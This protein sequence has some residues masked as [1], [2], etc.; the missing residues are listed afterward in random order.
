MP[1][2]RAPSPR[3]TPKPIVRRKRGQSGFTLVE[4][5]IA[6]GILALSLSVVFGALSNGIWQVR[7][8]DAGAQA[9][10]LVQSVLARVGT[11]VPLREGQA[12]GQFPGGF[13]WHL[14]VQGFGDAADRQV[15]PV[16]AYAVTAE[17]FWEDASQRRSVLVRTLR[18]G[19][20]EPAR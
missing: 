7:Q 3:L 17:V 18:L 5:V 9:G 19:P 20:K 10:L 6:L 1:A 2:A 13:G 15:W 8:A 14:L 16:S 11:E 12:E 4:V